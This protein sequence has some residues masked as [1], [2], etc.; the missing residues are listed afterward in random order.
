MACLINSYIFCLRVI[1]STGASTGCVKIHYE[2]FGKNRLL[3]PSTVNS[4]TKHFHQKVLPLFPVALL[5]G[6]ILIVSHCLFLSS[7]YH[8]NCLS[9]LSISPPTLLDYAF[10]IFF[11]IDL[12]IFLSIHLAIYPSISVSLQIYS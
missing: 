11:F 8:Q 2:I 7:L 4:I 10:N 9:L 12:S 3:L 6:C 5:Q 1:A